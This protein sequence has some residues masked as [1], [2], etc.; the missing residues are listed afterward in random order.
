[1][2]RPK[3]ELAP[4]S[5]FG[6]KKLLKTNDA[7]KHKAVLISY[8]KLNDAAQEQVNI[9]LLG[10]GDDSNAYREGLLVKS[11]FE[12]ATFN[13][14][15][16]NVEKYLAK[17]RA[18]TGSFLLTP[19][20]RMEIGFR[21]CKSDV[22]ISTSVKRKGVSSYSKD[23]A[24]FVLGVNDVIQLSL[25]NAPTG[26]GKTV[27][28]ILGAMSKVAT[29]EAYVEQAEIFQK[30]RVTGIHVPHL[31]LQAMPPIT[32][33]KLS[34][35]II[36]LVPSPVM[37]QWEDTS[38]ML[39]KTFGKSR[40]ETWSGLSALTRAAKGTVGIKRTLVQAIEHCEKNNCALFWVLEA[41]TKS[42]VAAL[43]TDATHAIAVR[44]IDE[45]TGLKGTEPRSKL[46]E[47]PCLSTVICNATLQQLSHHTSHQPNHPLRRALGNKNLDLNRPS[48]SAIAIMTSVPS[49]LRMAVGMSMEPL[50]PAGILKMSLLVKIKSLAGV[51]NDTDMIIRSIDD[52]ISGLIV[53]QHAYMTE[54]DTLALTK[55]CKDI[56]NRVDDSKTISETLLCAIESV[57]VDLADIPPTPANYEYVDDAGDLRTGLNADDRIMVSKNERRKRVYGTMIRVFGRLNE[58]FTKNVIECPVTLCEIPPEHL[59]ILGCCTTFIDGRIIPKL[60]PRVCIQCRSPIQEVMKTSQAIST[61]EKEPPIQKTVDMKEDARILVGNVKSLVGAFKSVAGVCCNSSV[62]AVVKSIA[63][64]IAFKPKGLRI[65]LCCNV[66]GCNMDER[67]DSQKTCDFIK[68]M[69]PELHS[70]T[71][72]GKGADVLRSFK[73][74][75]NSNRLLII[76]TGRGSTSLPGIDLGNTNLVIFDRLSE[77]GK[78]TSAKIIQ[79]IGRAMRP[80]KASIEETQKN[81]N[82]F[83]KHG[84]SIHPPKFTI[85]IDRFQT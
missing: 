78:I 39:S 34:R 10:Q 37:K 25:Y 23:V 22:E 69:I 1:V 55:R 42:S 49:W 36:A 47:S 84:K 68:S 46:A 27:C 33:V 80:Q 53:R 8:K 26:S 30:S 44:I 2:F 73:K 79:A 48:D 65:L 28:T 74:V 75:D 45:G 3:P 70:V 20:Q 41:T 50:M 12:S 13:T 7:C 54:E 62:D 66:Y 85:F 18:N 63:F 72:I 15:Y 67:R 51:L 38:Q 56:L 60:S 77:N 9:T 16:A 21:A 81:I 71:T 61:F 6:I 35:V 14:A 40:W 29:R 43:R 31:G 83:R 82:Y 52:V 76:N 17:S 57:N 32:K 5:H 59:C 4:S 58:V 19:F 64:T 11:N 24:T